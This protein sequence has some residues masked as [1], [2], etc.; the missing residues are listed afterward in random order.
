LWKKLYCCI[1]SSVHSILRNFTLLTYTALARSTILWDQGS[2]YA[3]F[4]FLT[5]T[6]MKSSVL[7]GKTPCNPV[8]AD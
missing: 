8:K 1:F 5:A 7:W 2:V 4:Q 3:G 6:L